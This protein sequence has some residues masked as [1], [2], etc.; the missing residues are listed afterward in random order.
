MKYAKE[1]KR[2]MAGLFAAVVIV[3]CNP[4]APTTAEPDT[5]TPVETMEHME[6]MGTDEAEGETEGTDTDTSTMDG[7]VQ[8]IS[9]EGGS[10]YYKP[11]VIKVKKGQ[12]V[13]VELKSVDMMHDFVIDELDVRTEII[14][15]GETTTVEFTADQVGEFEF[16]CSVGQ[17]R[18]NGMVGTL[19][20]EE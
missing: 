1:I 5:V 7:D 4:A 16:Y 9:V 14:P 19:I 20:V 15:S 11:E 2:L 10:F 17:H 18:A 6:T 8:V 12:K 3:G 13:R